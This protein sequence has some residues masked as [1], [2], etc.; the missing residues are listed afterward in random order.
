MKV[1]IIDY[2]AGNIQSLKFAFQRFGIEAEL[3]KN[4]EVVSSADRVIFPGVGEASSAMLK[5]KETGLDRL[6]PELTQP[7]LGICL[8]MQ[9]MCEHSDEG[10]TR[11]L[12][13]FKDPVVRFDNALKVPQIGW[14]QIEELQSP[15]F[16]GVPEKSYMYLVHSYYV[17]VSDHA[18]ARC[19]YG[20]WYAS[21]LRYKNFYGT[22]FHPEKSGET[23]QL[24]LENFIRT[25]TEELIYENNTG[26]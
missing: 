8:G 3:S 23:G 18:I 17:P 20:D 24:I 21:A 10:N 15:L 19:L 6:I 16:R 7:V 26:N 1:V 25:K 14:N 22:Q 12:A 2:G 4:P 13:I 11:G 9:L 5:L